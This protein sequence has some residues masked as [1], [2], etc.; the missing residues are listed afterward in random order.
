ME[1]K[2]DGNI[3]V[4]CKRLFGFKEWRDG[5][6]RSIRMWNYYFFSKNGGCAPPRSIKREFNKT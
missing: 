2:G 1:R 3:V 6:K 4:E 5:G